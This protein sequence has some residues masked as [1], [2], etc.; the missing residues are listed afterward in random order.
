MLRAE[1]VSLFFEKGRVLMRKGMDDLEQEMLAFSRDWDREKDG[2]PNR[3]D[4][5]AWALTR[6][7]RIVTE[8]PIA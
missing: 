8:I 6:L 5:M 1:P 7:G 3:L 2:S 4:A